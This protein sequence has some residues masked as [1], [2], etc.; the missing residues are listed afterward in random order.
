MLIDAGVPGV[1]DGGGGGGGGGGGPGGG[2]VVAFA[3]ATKISGLPE[4]PSSVANREFPPPAP[5]IQLPTVAIPLES[6]TA[7]APVIDPPPLRI[8]KMTEMPATPTPPA[9]ETFT[10]GAIAT[11]VFGGAVCWSPAKIE[12]DAGGFDGG[13]GGT[14]SPVTVD[15]FCAVAVNTTGLPSRP[16]AVALSVFTPLDAPSVQPPT[17]AMPASS[18]ATVAPLTLPPPA[19]TVN[20]TDAPD[21]GNPEASVTM[22]DGEM[23]T[24]ADAAAVCPSPS[25][26]RIFAAG[27]AVTRMVPVPLTFSDVAV[28]V[29]VPGATAVTSPVDASIFAID[30]LLV[31]QVTARPVSGTPSPSDV[32]ALSFVDCPATRV[33]LAGFTATEATPASTKTA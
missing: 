20:V 13:G 4:T 23:A 14:G 32:T 26:N 2:E 17:R 29:A 19:V 16:D 31:A 27:P 22:T 24:A 6:L 9:S 12:I 33:V 10:A 7:T 3:V 11:A 21:T 25:Y 30:S 1:H 15:D 18:V 5:S 28:I 8:E